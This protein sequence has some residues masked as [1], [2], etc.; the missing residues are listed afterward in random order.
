MSYLESKICY[1]FLPTFAFVF[2]PDFVVTSPF[3][4]R[5]QLVGFLFVIRLLRI[6][7]ASMIVCEEGCM[8]LAPA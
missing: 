5:G 4:C 3:L 8:K 1:H 7:C 6:I 2:C